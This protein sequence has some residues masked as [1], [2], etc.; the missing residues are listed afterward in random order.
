MT[1]SIQLHFRKL[2]SLCR[3]NKQCICRSSHF[4]YL[5]VYT[6]LR[7]CLNAVHKFLIKVLHFRL[8]ICAIMSE[9]FLIFYELYNVYCIS[10]QLKL[11]VNVINRMLWPYSVK[12][13]KMS[14]M[15]ELRD[16]QHETTSWVSTWPWECQ[17]NP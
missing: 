4:W 3:K 1:L 10:V 8:K 11:T 9:Q 12:T 16:L 17:V 14:W 7:Y 6:D 15:Q 2:S 13:N 5:T